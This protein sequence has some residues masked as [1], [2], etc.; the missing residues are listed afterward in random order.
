MAT[1]KRPLLETTGVKSSG[2]SLLWNAHGERVLCRKL[3]SSE[4]HGVMYL[5]RMKLDQQPPLSPGNELADPNQDAASSSSQPYTISP[6]FVKS[7]SALDLDTIGGP[8]SRSLYI[9]HFQYCEG[10]I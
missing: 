10:A 2:L 3:F 9:T 4:A 5:H 6:P 1:T 7:T 8:S